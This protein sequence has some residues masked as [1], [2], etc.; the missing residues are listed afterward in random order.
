MITCPECSNRHIISDHLKFFRDQSFTIEDLMRQKGQLVKRGTLGGKGD[1]EF[2][3]DGSETKRK[4]VE[5][6]Q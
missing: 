1:V 5:G 2:W 4:N 3:D 6:S